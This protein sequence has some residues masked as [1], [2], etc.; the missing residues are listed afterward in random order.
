MRG[1]NPPPIAGTFNQ[2]EGR[3][4]GHSVRGTDVVPAVLRRQRPLLPRGANALRGHAPVS[5]GDPARHAADLWLAIHDTHG[6]E[7]DVKRGKAY[8]ARDEEYHI[9]Q[10]EHSMRLHGGGHRARHQISHHLSLWT[11]ALG[12][13]VP[14]ALRIMFRDLSQSVCVGVN[15]PVDQHSKRVFKTLVQPCWPAS[16]HTSAAQ[17]HDHQPAPFLRPSAAVATAAPDR[18]TPL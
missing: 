13:R 4:E 8:G 12:G 15:Q 10:K 5:P 7:H 14:A 16:E 6:A 2:E 3:S 1:R 11:L 17:L 18:A 9:H